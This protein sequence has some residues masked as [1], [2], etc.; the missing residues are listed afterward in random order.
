[1]TGYKCAHLQYKYDTKITFEERLHLKKDYSDAWLV[2]RYTC[3]YH[4]IQLI[5]SDMSWSAIHSLK[6]NCPC[7]CTKACL[8]YRRSFSWFWE[9]VAAPDRTRV[10][11]S[12]RN[13]EFH[14]VLFFF[15]YLHKFHSTVW[16]FYTM[17]ATVYTHC[18]TQSPCTGFTV[19]GAG[20]GCFLLLCVCCVT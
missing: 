3:I 19:F 13:W 5:T 4:V 9:G 6:P 16:N 2:K 18:K 10:V 12:S 1:M 15:L 17:V 11:F 8:D 14:L 20:R 7:V